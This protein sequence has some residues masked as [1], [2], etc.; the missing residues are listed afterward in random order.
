MSRAEANT[1]PRLPGEVDT[2]EHSER[3]SGEGDS[4]RTVRLESPPHPARSF[5][6]RH[7]LPASGAREPAGRMS[8]TDY[9]YSPSIL[10]RAPDFT[11]DIL[12]VVGGLYGNLAALG[13]I[14]RLAAQ[15]RSPV[16]IVFNG[17][18]H[19]FDAEPDWFAEIERGIAR[20]RAMRG[21]VETEIARAG[22]IGAGCGC[23]YPE[24]VDEGVVA[25]SNEILATLRGAASATGLAKTLTA[26][27]MH[28]VARVGGLRVGIVHGD[29]ASLAGWRFAHDA[30]DDPANRSWLE[31]IQ[32][33]SA[34]DVFASTHT[35]LAALR[36]FALAGGRLTIINNGAAGMAN[37]SGSAF[38]LISRI[39]TT[40]SPHPAVYDLGRNG[41]FVDAIPIDYDLHEFLARFDKRWPPDSPAHASY[42]RRIVDGPAHTLEQARGA[43]RPAA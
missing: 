7:P 41:V 14:D 18:Y 30:L 9:R 35:C 25:R 5:A 4:P 24:S 16:T 29:A 11:A 6:A 33:K 37:F 19:W 39:A 10:N 34:I 23:A 17:D 20:H 12:Y 40:P 13:A 8:P 21:N 36:D 2:R 38:G 32:A 27:P 43:R 28:L 26:L 15:E 42:Y 31:D 3:V 1:S 22:D